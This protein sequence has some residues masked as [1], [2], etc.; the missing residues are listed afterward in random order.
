MLAAIINLHTWMQDTIYETKL[1]L[2]YIV[3]ARVH[4]IAIATGDYM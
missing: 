3:T 2:L 1:F 4:N